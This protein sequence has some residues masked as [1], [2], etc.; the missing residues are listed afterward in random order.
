MIIRKLLEIES[1]VCGRKTPSDMNDDS[2]NAHYS[3]SRGEEI[4]ILDM[5]LPHLVRAYSNMIDYDKEWHD[6]SYNEGWNDALE[7]LKK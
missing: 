6:K 1:I 2:L 3:K 5:H 4:K 7:S